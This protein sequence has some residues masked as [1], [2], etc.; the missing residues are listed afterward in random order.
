[1]RKDTNDHEEIESDKC[2]GIEIG[3]TGKVVGRNKIQIIRGWG[4][5]EPPEN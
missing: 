5:V 1:M 2:R 4:G 3:R